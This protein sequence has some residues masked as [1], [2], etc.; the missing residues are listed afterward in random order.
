MI[1]SRTVG[2]LG[3]GFLAADLVRIPVLGQV[4]QPGV[5]A[6]DATAFYAG[7]EGRVLASAVLL[8]LGM[9]LALAFFAA[10]AGLVDDRSLAAAVYGA[11]VVVAAIDLAR[12]AGLA[13][14]GLRADDL[15]PDGVLV[16]HLL[17][18]VLGGLIGF[19]IA[20]G[21]AALGIAMGRADGW[22]SWFAAAGLVL[23]GAWLLSCLRI[24]T[25]SSLA[26]AAGAGVFA[27]SAVLVAL[28]A[29]AFLRD[30]TPVAA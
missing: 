30:R 13:A 10:V 11:I 2:L 20:T 27:V 16:L 21:V 19:P 26:W 1:H 15:G 18:T 3:L 8:G 9:T 6:A 17:V 28:L 7:N 12:V 22:P 5:S 24:T 14:L 29:V 23:A 4:P 25:T